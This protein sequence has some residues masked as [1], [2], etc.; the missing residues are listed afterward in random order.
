MDNKK[1]I[2]NSLILHKENVKEFEDC[3]KEDSMDNI[4]IF[5]V[6][7]SIGLEGKIFLHKPNKSIPEWS[8]NINKLASE[9]I[10]IE[11]N[12]SNKAVIIFK[13][14]N[15]FFSLTYGYGK[16][17]LNEST[18]IRNFGLIVAANLIDTNK[19]KS[20]NSMTIEDAIV[21]T[22]KQSSDYG[23][24]EQF[25]VNKQ[26]EI[27]KAISGSPS[28]E[29]IAKFIIG[30]DSLV[31]TRKMNI[32]EIKADIKY[33]YEVYKKDDYKKNGFEWLDNIQKVKDSLLKENL[34][35]NLV[36]AVQN[37]A[38]GLLIAPNKI[39][40][41]EDIKGFYLTGLGKINIAE[42]S[43]DIEYDKYFYEI[44]KNKGISVIDKL[45]RDSLHAVNDNSEDQKIS[46][47]YDALIFETSFEDSK[48]LLCYG[49]W[50]EINK[51]YYARIKKKIKDAPVCNRKLPPCKENESE[52][53]YNERICKETNGFI[54]M[55]KKNYQPKEYG[56]SKIEPCDILTE[57]KQFIH[58]KKG[59]ASSKLSHLFSQA[60]VSSMLLSTEKELR[61][62]INKVA[63][64]KIGYNLLNK[65]DNNMDYETVIAIISKK[66]DSIE[67]VIPFFALVNLSNTLDRL[68]TMNFK[69]SLLLIK[70]D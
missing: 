50:Y 65:S 37:D 28:S 64:K 8:V 42:V 67:N 66:L 70:Q 34:N 59:G 41:W 12:V 31:A 39:I 6:K 29:S 10:D 57:S 61:T 16:S 38:S 26:S 20:L 60:L 4:D 44:R 5:D 24:Q 63:N 25:Q 18:I 17:L 53:D 13:Y 55:D 15:R 9:R 2:K 7:K 47:I 14:K 56:R 27:L 45:K 69:Y 23:N 58:V 22:Q 43:F 11:A 1:T 30:T 54:L 40:N 19:I 3:M 49:D 48:Y 35:K 52:G 21:D 46:N 33:Y 62:H 32:E 68:A 36:L 51:S